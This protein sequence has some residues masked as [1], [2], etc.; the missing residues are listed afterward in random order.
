MVEEKVDA[1]DQYGDGDDYN[2]SRA[3]PL[4]EQTIYEDDQELEACTKPTDLG[5]EPVT[6]LWSEQEDCYHQPLGNAEEEETHP[7]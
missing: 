3:R 7:H 1:W 6:G 4:V 2:L 5:F